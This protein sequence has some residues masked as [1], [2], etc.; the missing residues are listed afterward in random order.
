MTKT[1]HT[2]AYTQ[3][4]AALRRQ[5]EALGVSQGVV[6]QRLGWTQ[7]KLSYA[8]SGERRLDVLEFFA[9][10]A[11][12]EM[13]APEAFALIQDQLDKSTRTRSSKRSARG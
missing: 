12:L 10:A 4:L 2:N 13:N 5:R 8:E 7:R 3:L 11:A 1:I 6:A 9:L